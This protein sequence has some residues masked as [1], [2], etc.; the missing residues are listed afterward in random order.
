MSDFTAIA[1]AC[2]LIIGRIEYNRWVRTPT[3][4]KPR[5]KNGAYK[6]LGD[7][8]FIINHA[9]MSRTV[10]WHPDKNDPLV[11]IDRQAVADRRRAASD[12]L[13]ADQ[14]RAAL[15]ARQIVDGAVLGPHPYLAAKG[16]PE[17][18]GLVSGENLIVPMMFGGK[19]CGCQIIAPDGGKKFLK[20]QRSGGASFTIGSK[21][22]DWWCEGYA[23]GLSVH[24]ALTALRMPGK[25]HVCFSAHNMAAIARTGVVV[26][27]RDESGA[28]EAAAIKTGLPYYLPEI[29]DFN[30]EMKRIG[31]FRASQQLRRFLLDA[32]VAG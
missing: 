19:L 16:F 5:K 26:A 23:T 30:D 27:D 29:G 24:K 3:A 20:G 9:T 18:H 13:R 1:E 4:D 6:H 14:E 2:G 32:P 22:G 15:K 17:M 25:V 12:M 10:I 7:C 31:L 8:A 21:G 28:G 11:K